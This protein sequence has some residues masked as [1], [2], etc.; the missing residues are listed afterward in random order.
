MDPLTMGEF[1]RRFGISTRVGWALLV[2]GASWAFL[3]L[4]AGAEI[5]EVPWVVGSFVAGFGFLP[6]AISLS[7]I[8]E[9][10]LLQRV[11]FVEPERI[12]A[13]GTQSPVGT[14]GTPT[15]AS[16]EQNGALETPFTGHPAVHTEWLVQQMSNGVVN[17]TWKTVGEGVQQ[18]EFA[19]GDGTVNVAPGNYDAILQKERLFSIDPSEGVPEPAATFLKSH[20]DLPTPETAEG[21]LRVLERYIPADDDVTVV[22]D[23]TQSS[24]PGVVRIEDGA[25][26]AL[27]RGDAELAQYTMRKRYKW[28]G[29]T[30]LVMILGGQAASFALSPP[31]LTTVLSVF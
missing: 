19:L 17:E 20:P 21:E 7:S 5:G 29:I 22:G 4:L 11:P 15:P 10:R 3:P 24:E 30:G 27:I 18:A 23:A 13:S 6:A 25:E 16:N 31:A 2:A 1:P 9:H 28:L 14:S 12:S 8:D 26:G